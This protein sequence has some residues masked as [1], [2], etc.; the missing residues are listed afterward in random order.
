MKI[1]H[2]EH[3]S[4]R[5]R[6]LA[7]LNISIQVVFP[8]SVAFTPAIAGAGSEGRFLQSQAMDELQTRVYTLAEGESA[9]TVA[10]K[11]NMSMEALRRLNQFRTFARGFDHLQSGDD[12]DVPLV[13]LP[14]VRWDDASAASVSSQSNADMQTQKVAGYASQAG[15]FLAS[16]AGGDAA[17]SMVRG[18]ASG[19]ASS[20]IQRWLSRFGTARVQ[21]D[22]SKNFSLKKSQLDLLVPLYEQKDSLVFTQSSIHRTDDRTQSNLGVGYRWFA[23][24]WMLGANTFLDYDLSRDHA[25]LGLGGEYW[26]DYL[27]LGF[28]TY[29]R[30]TNWKNS[31]DLEDYEERPANGWDLRAQ[32]WLPSLPHLGGKLTYEQY[33]GEEVALFGRDNRQRNPYAITAGVNYTPVPLLTFSAEQRQGQSGKSDTRFGMDMSYQ[34][35][36]PWLHQ[37]N[38]DEV[39]A[40]RSLVG[41]R[42]D[43]VER[44][45]NIVLEY[46]KKE[47]IRLR[48]ADLVTGYAGEQKSLGVS[49]NSK[50]GLER[51][52]W[53]AS[54]LIAAGGKI[55][56]NGESWT[57]VLPDYRSGVEAVN[58]YT[59]SGVAVDKKGNVSGRA[60]TQV[61]VTQAAIDTTT[62]SLSPPAA[63]LPADG[64][65]QQ[66]FVLKV[67]DKEGRPVDIAENEISVKKTARLRGSSNATVS[68]F[69]RRAAGEYV[70]TVTSGT[71]PEAF[72]ITPSARNTKFASAD[73][74]LTADNATA[75]VN[76]LDVVENNAIADGKSQNRFR[77][78]V[79]DG[80]NNPVP[81]QPVSLQADNSATV[82]KSAITEADGTVIVPVTSPLAGD[83]TLTASVNNKG[84]KTLKLSFRPDQG[85]ARIEQ[86]DLNILPEVSLAD[87]KTEKTVTARVTDAKGNAVPDIMVTFSADKSAV[88]AEKKAKTNALGRVTTTLTSTVAGISHVAASVNSQ[89]TSKETTFT[90]NNATAIVT[91]VNTAA[92]S[93]VAD[94]VTAVTF[95][96]L[97]KDQ[98]GNP[99]SGIPVDWK[100]DK[101]SSIVAFNHTQ[102][103]TSEEG[104]A[105]TRVTSTRAYGDVVVT[106]ST[107]ASSKAA[108]PFT[109]VADKQNPVISTFSSNKQTLTANGKDTVVL[110]VGITDS[111]GNPLSGVA[112]A[113]S[114]GNNA[115]M[116]PS[117]P[118]TDANG[119]ASA[120]LT[121]L[122]AGQIT[123]S[124]SL[125][126]SGEKLLTLMAVSD[127]Q[128]A[129]VRVTA[130]TT[131][132]TVGQTQPTIFTA[133]V[134][135]GNNNPV[136]GTS[137]AW[138]A[139]H[140]QLSDAVS[141]TNAEGKTTVQLTGTEAAL[142]TVTA[143]LTNGQKGSA[144][145]TFAPG[146]PVGEHSQ[147]SV[148]PQ[149][150][151]ADGTSEALASL[152][153]R[154]KW[155]NPVPGKTI[156]WSA[157]TKSGIHFAPVEKGE[158]VYQAAVT[159]AAEGVWSLKA[160]SGTVNLQAPLAL[161][162]NQDS[163]Q[164]ESVSVS[165]PGTAKA[166]GQETVTI[167]AQVKDKNGNTKLKGVAVGWS[168]TLGTLASSLS[169]TD[170]NGVAD[171]TLS[172]RAA[173]SARVSAMLGGGELVQANKAVSFSAGDISAD[174]SSISLS[175][176]TII[177]AKEATTLS[178]TARDAEGNMLPGLKDK[179]AAGFTPDLN[180]A[181]SA[182]SEVSPGI[183]EASI[184]GKKSGT[185][186]VSAD[187]SNIRISRTAPL[188]L[189]ADNETAKVKGSINVTPASATVGDVVTYTAVLMDVNE[190]ALGAGIPVTWSANEGSKLSAQMTRTDESGTARVTLSRQ[191]AGTAKVD[192]ILPS[193]TTSA[194][195][196]VFSAGDVDENRSDLTLAPSV[197]I[198]GKETSALVLTL[199]DSN[200]NLLT[201]RSVSGHSDNL[202]VTIGESQENG[203]GPGRY[204]M[205]VSSDKAGS[206]TLT[207]KVGDKALNKS[208]ILT[209]KGDTDS[210][211]LTAVTADK[212]RLTAGDTKGVTYS[213]TVTDAKGNPLNNVVVSWQL[214]GQAESYAPT[215][216]TNEQG[217]ATTTVKSHTAGLL[218]M[219]AYL[220]ADNYVQADNVTVVAG[221]IKNATFGADK[222]S[223]GSDGKD[224]VTLMAS[225]ED[226]YGNPVTGKSVIIEGG[227]SLPGFKLSAVKDQQNG[228]YVATGTATT[229]GQITLSAHVDGK[230]VGDA[231]VITVG[232]ITPD[233]RFDNADQPVTWTRTFTSSQAV[234]GM[235]EGVG[236]MWSSSDTSVATVD[237]SGKVT[238]LKSGSARISVY[239]PGNEQYNQA[240]ASYNL[241]VS[242]A[243]P[244]L[245]AGTGDP[246]TAVWADGKERNITATYTNSDVQTGLK[247]SYSAKNEA[248]VTVDNTGRLTA[249]KPGATTVTVSTPETDQ[250]VAASADVAYVLNKA[251]ADVS[252]GTSTVKTT[253]EESFTLQKPVT[254]LTSQASIKWAS[255]NANVVNVSDSGAVQGNVGKGQTR[256]TLSVLA[257]DYY[258]ASSGYYDV[259]VYTKPSISLGEVSYI[260][261][262]SKGS[263]GTWT[264]VF[265]DDTISVTWS[266][267]A[268][269][270]FS[271]PASVTVSILD[272]NNNVLASKEEQSPS[273]SKTTTVNPNSAL[274][275]KTVHV[276]LVAKGYGNLET[277]KSSSTIGVRNLNPKSIWTA[278]TVRSQV[279]TIT[280]QGE[281]SSCQESHLGR[282]HWN[283]AVITGDSIN[284]GGKTLIS[285]MSVK[286][287]I[288]ATQ[289]GS[290]SATGDFPTSYSKV[291]TNQKVAFGTRKI[292][293][294][295]WSNHIG[296][297]RVGIAV[298]YAGQDYEYWASESHGWGGNG[299]G[300]YVDR[301]DSF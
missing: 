296:G 172:S 104:I 17:S 24:D 215:S 182:F 34:P 271:K 214:R 185:T 136:A 175:P 273:G 221:D 140:N 111:N 6:L 187:V 190:N 86:K 272:S 4:R 33:Y 230:K 235:P 28:N 196:V 15:S 217:V 256:L 191:L 267:D 219:S 194:P 161:L 132:A 294:S 74:K 124:A 165:G 268:S 154:D 254:T 89:S 180:M 258:N 106:A 108:S 45:N 166:D 99:L 281:D 236:Q 134:I 49:V 141:Q 103:A 87:G 223:I 189:K 264:P 44:N 20:E 156:D 61:T 285:P 59:V 63:V 36:V 57:V 288:T 192:L 265:T 121:T 72:T 7:W 37:I 148:S 95:R 71:M 96:A 243:D 158:G 287:K 41:S 227:N 109:F 173:G 118:V 39:A 8:L 168:T 178:V 174:K 40:M 234:R 27:K 278:L 210:W 228:H 53:S 150:I 240:M 188:T 2:I 186:Q 84:N 105:E 147:L 13:P 262:G 116:T 75:M 249:V 301:I 242:R 177:A 257:N 222:T 64:A 43:L 69:T 275:G 55:V 137:V 14:E 251:T 245:K 159:G 113:L 120:N 293:S 23:G 277:N 250:F 30:L 259:M 201:G 155:D 232:A 70:M 145:V 241:D 90:G 299:D 179:I 21:L 205:S 11:H 12:L 146:E 1:S 67:N 101:D 68:S 54:P 244:G 9:A 139:S 209:V 261:K 48:M 238:L 170:E 16:D 199:R 181:V 290:T 117:R 51:I 144:Q 123:I 102:T 216:R 224:T 203:N 42:Y 32:Y 160:Q 300:M 138:Q 266:A 22:T 263:S 143:V 130:N 129:G 233:L 200:G 252:F 298:S 78:T 255:S 282:D 19:A 80:Q 291:T 171:I 284:F 127:E 198:A 110:T 226:T 119:M 35:G 163:A 26:R 18:M 213:A 126:K 133:T 237:G 204:T 92:A 79:V 269:D 50:Y 10:K 66:E 65:S 231:V 3:V 289:N 31:P 93:G 229:K 5:M 286:A 77:V 157:D 125:D 47:V 225:L 295:C 131:S 83:T 211:K 246:V 276:A 292:A 184:S 208:R 167:R 279:K 58:S 212:T 239:T 195:D 149:S 38:P 112:V 94:G 197:I 193:G 247:A 100:S 169:T 107:N 280:S 260:S 297:Y 253:D 274:W 98:N 220:D 62:S 207:V 56:Q 88:L 202:D 183:Y 218:Q 162:A 152:I 25:R 46:R 97:I 135:D 128:T 82:V 153:L 142:T 176:S 76:A 91:A 52:D 60:E 248:I 85:T 29:S 151:T 114:N 270:E 81:G 73:V 164:I 206:A 122:N 283:N 115:G